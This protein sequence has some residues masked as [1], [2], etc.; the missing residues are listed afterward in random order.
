[1][2]DTKKGTLRQKRNIDKMISTNSKIE[3]LS[4]K[5]EGIQREELSDTVYAPA[6]L[7]EYAKGKTYFVQTYGCQGN[8]RDGETIAGILE[9][10]GF[11][12]AK[13]YK[14]SDLFLLNTCAVRENAED[15]VYGKSGEV[16]KLKRSNPDMIFGICGC[17][18]QESD[19]TKDMLQR[20]PQIDLI[21]GT[22]NIQN[23]PV[24]LEEL[25]REEKTVVEIVT[26]KATVVEN[27][28][29]VRQHQVKGFVNVM[30]GCDKFCTYCIVPYTRGKERSRTEESI[31]NEVKEMMANGYKEVTLVGQSINNYGIDIGTTF[32]N[33]LMKVSDLG[34]ERIR[35]TTSNP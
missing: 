16:V 12:K 35:F 10:L 15:K 5:R 33:I 2:R 11:T 26:D 17:I 6:I 27:L 21:F 13:D 14:E 22:H 24:L 28:P 4:A 19:I 8:E 25:I 30:Y 32:A 1:M 29:T 20:F 34:I 23:L 3:D 31:L 18:P 7:T 9:A